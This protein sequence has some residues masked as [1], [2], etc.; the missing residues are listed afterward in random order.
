[1]VGRLREG[2]GD[3]FAF[4]DGYEVMLGVGGSTAFW[5]AMVFGLIEERSEH[6]VFGEFSSKF[7]KGVKLAPHLAEP[8]V[9]ESEPGTRPDA[10]ARDDV[11]FYALS[12]NET[13]TGVRMPVTRPSPKG[14][15]A[16]DATSAA[17][18]TDVDLRECD[19]YY[20]APQK[21]FASDGGLWIA[22]V[23]PAAV[24][25]IGAL[26][27]S[28]RYIPPFFDLQTA[29]ENSRKNQT[30]NTPGLASVFLMVDQIEW[31]LEKGGLSWA[32]QRCDESSEILY[33]WAEGHRVA[34]P[35]VKDP[36]HRSHTVG[37]IDFSPDV[38]ADSIAKV[39]RANGIVDTEPYRKLGRNQLRVAMYPAIDP[40]D[41]A[42]LTQ[43]IDYVIDV[44]RDS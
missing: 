36:E 34:V 8:V 4:P 38:D 12:E 35:F 6:L 1:M 44:L 39:L 5:D 33:G 22:I 30:Y 10:E 9:I 32:T 29:I 24:E 11:D 18:G 20:F 17:G 28:G 7:A 14:L 2:L 27:T 26:A 13:S 23:S 40:S 21:C 43:S 25:R 41:V 16:V 3:L 15:V 31:M 37:T 19:V 42:L